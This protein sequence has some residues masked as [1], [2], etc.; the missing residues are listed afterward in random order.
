MKLPLERTLCVVAITFVAAAFPRTVSASPITFDGFFR[1]AGYGKVAVGNNG[2]SGS[3]GSDSWALALGLHS[4]GETTQSSVARTAPTGTMSASASSSFEFVS[5]HVLGS[6][7]TAPDAHYHSQTDANNASNQVGEFASAATPF[8]F[9]FS[10]GG[11]YWAVDWVFTSTATGYDDVSLGI[12]A[13]CCGGGSFIAGS[14]APGTLSGSNFGF[15]AADYMQFGVNN[16]LFVAGEADGRRNYVSGTL[17]V[18]FRFSD[19]PITEP[20]S[21]E[22]AAVP[23][24]ASLLLLGTG[25]LAMVRTI[26]RRRK[27]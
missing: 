20:L 26:R 4:V 5:A 27:V 3:F 11:V 17:D 22:P 8:Q 10:Q 19:A 15:D 9:D 14:Q 7:V 21:L 1:D 6:S 12:A 25:G 18:W 2:V 16:I 13:S 24:P 23:E